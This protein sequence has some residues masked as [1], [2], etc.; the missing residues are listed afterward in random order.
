MRGLFPAEI[1]GE[2][3]RVRMAAPDF[4]AE[5]DKQISQGQEEFI[6]SAWIPGVEELDK[7]P[8]IRLQKH[9]PAPFFDL[10]FQ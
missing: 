5:G 6:G 7:V 2:H 10:K 4:F 9:F 3:R 1:V 8:A